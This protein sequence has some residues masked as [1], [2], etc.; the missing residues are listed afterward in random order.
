MGRVIGEE[1]GLGSDVMIL[2]EVRLWE[3]GRRGG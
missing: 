3:E 2:N 1:V